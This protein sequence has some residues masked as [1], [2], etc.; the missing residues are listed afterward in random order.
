MRLWQLAIAWSCAGCALVTDFDRYSENV[1]S[2][3]DTSIVKP[4]SETSVDTATIDDTTIAVDTGVMDTTVADT[5]T[6]PP[7]TSM[8]DV[9]VTCAV[10]KCAS[11]CTVLKEDATNCG[12][13]GKTCAPGEYCRNGACTCT[14]GLTKCSSGCVDLAGHHEHCGACLTVCSREDNTC[15]FTDPWGG[16][17][18]ALDEGGCG[19]KTGRTHCFGNHCFD[20]RTDE[21]NCGDCGKVCNRD[22]VCV[23]GCKKAFPRTAA[24]CPTGYI[25]CPPLP[26]NTYRICVEGTA[27][28]G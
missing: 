28:P 12:I 5:F 26:G 19:T 7:D 1:D 20:L 2:A 24:S 23:S 8:P 13:C 25:D 27:C 10:D 3:A 6:P 4:T 17:I 11:G 14:P 15:R 9:M 18:C 16:Y 22:E 21:T